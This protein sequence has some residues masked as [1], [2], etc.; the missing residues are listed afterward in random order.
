V[1]TPRRYDATRR[2]E[3]AELQR[4][5]TRRRVVEAARRLFLQKGYVA[6]TM[7]EI[8]REAGVAAQTVYLSFTGKA[9]LLHRVADVAIAGDHDELTV[10]QRDAWQAMAGEQDPVRQVELLADLMAAIARRMAPVWHAYREAAAVDARAATDMT[11]LLRA[12]HESLTQAIRLLPAD[13][14]RR[15]LADTVDG[16]WTISSIDGYLLLTRH[17]GWDHEQWRRWLVDTAIVQILSP[18]PPER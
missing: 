18:A 14:L 5:E 15:P 11:E 4:R 13:R 7:T 8:A 10:Y 2:R 9:E 3:R 17:R 6:T 16:F 12:R 1:S